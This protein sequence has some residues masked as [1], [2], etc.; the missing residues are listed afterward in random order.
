MAP[1]YFA[2]RLLAALFVCCIN[3]VV[4]FVLCMS[5]VWQL[6]A[7]TRGNW[8]KPTLFFCSFHFS[9][10]RAKKIEGD[11]IYIRHSLLML[12][13]CIPSGDVSLCL[14]FLALWH[15]GFCL[16][17]RSHVAW[18]T[19]FA[20]AQ[21]IGCRLHG[22]CLCVCVWQCNS[23]LVISGECCWT[24]NKYWVMIGILTLALAYT[25]FKEP[26]FESILFNLSLMISP[27]M[28]LMS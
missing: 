6:N 21:M 26:A 23:S 10:K 2:C 15:N 13:V 8:N 3:T 27:V 1:N 17:S 28:W 5:K 24:S 9:Q 19:L 25:N 4:N 11:S 7:S 14:Y 16:I 18:F 20:S 12:E 22:K